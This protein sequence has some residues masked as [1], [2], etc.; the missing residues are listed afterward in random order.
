MGGSHHSNAVAV[1]PT[2]IQTFRWRAFDRLGARRYGRDSTANEESL[3]LKLQE[4]GLNAISIQVVN[5]VWTLKTRIPQKQFAAW[6]RQLATL[7]DAGIPITEALELSQRSSL[8]PQLKHHIETLVQ[9]TRAGARLSHAMC[10]L[11]PP[12]DATFVAGIRGAEQSGD[13]ANTLNLLATQAERSQALRASVIAALMYPIAVLAIAL[14]ALIGMLVG[15][16]PAFELQFQNWDVPLPAIT[17]SLLWMSRNLIA[18]GWEIIALAGLTWMLVKRTLA[19]FDAARMARDRLWLALPVIGPIHRQ[20]C[21]SRFG[22]TLSMLLHAGVDLLE[23]VDV[24]GESTANLRYRTHAKSIQQ[25]LSAGTELST[26]MACTGAFPDALIHLCEIGERSG[27][28][29][30]LL[31]KAAALLDQESQSHLSG[32]TSLIEPILVTLLGC[33]IGAMVMALYMPIF[34]LGH[35]L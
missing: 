15:V 18:H 10:T 28:L 24:A 5:P 19:R 13:L 2:Q 33:M 9:A 35:L 4:Q 8:H 26:A 32:L 25:A 31:H 6:T 17:Q 34:Q 21:V 16:V 30:D 27:R 23:A 20:L 22:N 29:G 14:I 1:R 12:L 3:R 7:T 11:K